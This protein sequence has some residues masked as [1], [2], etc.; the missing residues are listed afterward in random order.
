MAHRGPLYVLGLMHSVVAPFKILVSPALSS[1]GLNKRSCKFIRIT[2]AL[3]VA[4]LYCRLFEAFVKHAKRPG[5]PTYGK[6]R[7][8]EAI[9]I[10]EHG[11]STGGSPRE[12]PSCSCIQCDPP[13]LLTPQAHHES[14]AHVIVAIMKLNNK[15]RPD[16]RA[17]VL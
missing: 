5:D 13:K 7:S 1:A 3:F 14:L 16:R 8:S 10:V 9:S 17:M 12:P 11:L 2:F 4:F 15:L 6:C